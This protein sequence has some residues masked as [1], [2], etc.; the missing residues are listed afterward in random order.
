MVNQ[1]RSQ[2]NVAAKSYC[3]YSQTAAHIR[4]HI[5]SNNGNCEASTSNTTRRC[6]RP[7]T[8][9]ARS[10]L[11]LSAA[12]EL[13]RWAVALARWSR[14]EGQYKVKAKCSNNTRQRFKTEYG[15]IRPYSSKVNIKAM[16]KTFSV[17]FASLETVFMPFK[18]TPEFGR[19]FVMAPLYGQAV[20]LCPCC[21]YLILRILVFASSLKSFDYQ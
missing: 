12:G 17:A 19:T 8:A 21:L 16:Q 14:G 13:G 10:S 7:P 11:R 2:P 3:K 5:S 9:C 1:A 20:N 15:R 4:H 6:T 18:S